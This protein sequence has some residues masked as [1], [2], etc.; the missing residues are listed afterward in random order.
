MTPSISPLYKK[1]ALAVSVFTLLALAWSAPEHSASLSQLLEHLK[2][3]DFQRAIVIEREQPSL[4]AM[5]RIEFDDVRWHKRVMCGDLPTSEPRWN[6]AQHKYREN[7]EHRNHNGAGRSANRHHSVAL[8]PASLTASRWSRGV[9]AAGGGWVRSRDGRV[10]SR[11]R[12][13]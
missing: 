10:V 11:R 4:G 1:V 5:V 12:A 7:H 8:P 6:S 13:S 3:L 9:G 2:E